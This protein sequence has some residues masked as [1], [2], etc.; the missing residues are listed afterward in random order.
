[1]KASEIKSKADK[2]QAMVITS[3]L[4]LWFTWK[5]LAKLT[6]SDVR[7]VIPLI[8]VY[9]AHTYQVLNQHLQ[10]CPSE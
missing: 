3:V 6:R 9:F 4:A 5:S 1:M 10:A 8:G 2:E 7:C